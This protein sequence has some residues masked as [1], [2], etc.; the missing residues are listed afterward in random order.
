MFT[1]SMIIYYELSM[2]FIVLILLFQDYTNGE[3]GTKK[4]TLY[5]LEGILSVFLLTVFSYV[6]AIE[7]L[8]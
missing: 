8:S 3:K 2:C 7:K 1:V 6:I 4:M 5:L